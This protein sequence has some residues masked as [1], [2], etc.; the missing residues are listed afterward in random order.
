MTIPAPY[1]IPFTKGFE[2]SFSKELFKIKK[3]IRSDPTVYELEDLEG[4]PIIG[5]FYKEELSAV[6]K[7]DDV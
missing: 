6:N 1:L 7:K 4:E 2:P 5:K 3:V